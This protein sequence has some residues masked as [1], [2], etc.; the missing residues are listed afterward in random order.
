MKIYALLF[1]AAAAVVNAQNDFTAACDGKSVGTACSYK[2]PDGSDEAGTC[3]S[4]ASPSACGPDYTE[5]DKCIMCGESTPTGDE[6]A[7]GDSG[8]FKENASVAACDNKDENDSCAF[9]TPDGQ[10]QTGVCVDQGA[11]ACGPVDSSSDSSGSVCYVCSTSPDDAG[12]VTA[13]PQTN[14]CS[15]KSIGDSCEISRSN[16]DGDA[17][18]IDGICD[19]TVENDDTGDGQLAC[20]PEANYNQ[21]PAPAVSGD[22][23]PAISNIL[24][25]AC[26]GKSEG[27]DCSYE[28]ADGNDVAGSCVSDQDELQCDNT[29][30]NSDSSDDPLVVACS[31]K[32]EGDSCSADFETITVDGTCTVDE[33]G[34]IFCSP[35][36]ASLRGRQ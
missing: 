28:D 8:G 22:D 27:D 34:N 5:S 25:V 29:D 9:V 16:G 20:V 32:S 30:T 36:P 6:G 23:D 17:L 10:K 15:G 1:A 14:E 24:N 19:D 3:I 21:A 18:T 2:L 7:G 26:D 11:G 13:A 12:G 31:G 4:P 33:G 35:V